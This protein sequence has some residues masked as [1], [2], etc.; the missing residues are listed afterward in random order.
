MLCTFSVLSTSSFRP[1]PDSRP[2]SQRQLFCYSSSSVS[3][4][5]CSSLSSNIPVVP[6]CEWPIRFAPDLYVPS[7]PLVP[8]YTRSALLVQLLAHCTHPFF[9]LR[10]TVHL[11]VRSLLLLCIFNIWSRFPSISVSYHLSLGFRFPLIIVNCYT[12]ELPHHPTSSL[13]FNHI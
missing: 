9:R 3:L 5:F 1:H 2:H 11:S 10:R 12:F 6:L 13:A 4:L 7:I 8:C